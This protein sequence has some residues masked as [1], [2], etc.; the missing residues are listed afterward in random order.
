[1]EA[2]EA[3]ADPPDLDFIFDAENLLATANIPPLVDNIAIPNNPGNQTT[4]ETPGRSSEPSSSDMGSASSQESN[5]EPESETNLENGAPQQ[6]I[7]AT[8]L[9]PD[10]D[11]PE[12][13]PPDLS[14]PD[15]SADIL[16]LTAAELQDIAASMTPLDDTIPDI[17][18]LLNGDSTLADF[19]RTLEPD[20]P[21]SEMSSMNVNND[22]SSSGET[23]PPGLE[24]LPPEQREELVPLMKRIVVDWLS[25]DPRVKWLDEMPETQ[26]R[27][28]LQ[29]HF[30]RK[31]RC[32]FSSLFPKCTTSHSFS[33]TSN[34]LVPLGSSRSVSE[35]KRSDD[36][37]EGHGPGRQSVF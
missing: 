33:L 17:D 23:L 36:Y 22:R 32:T 3:S 5:E 15:P 7:A 2:P 25:D 9:V 14:S 35:R 37:P 6:D 29:D 8:P 13:S 30:L 19:A 16:N 1:M 4:E 24:V 34:F 20:A 31:L 26:K 21:P 18:L 10:N 11:S 12:V 28:R 27:L